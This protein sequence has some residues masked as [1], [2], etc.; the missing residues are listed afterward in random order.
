MIRKKQPLHPG[1]SIHFF[2]K[3]EAWSEIGL[4]VVNEERSVFG[5]LDDGEMLGFLNEEHKESVRSVLCELDPLVRRA[6]ARGRTALVKPM[7][8]LASWLDGPGAVARWTVAVS[9]WTATPMY[10]ACQAGHL[11]DAK[12]LL[13]V[14]GAEDVRTPN[15]NGRTP[16]WIACK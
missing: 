2:N 7:N 4:A 6:A 8:A 9:R 1:W 11:E 3:A 10:A 12:W 15:S 14:G 13:E 5:D 16:M